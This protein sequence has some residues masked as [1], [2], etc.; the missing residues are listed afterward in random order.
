MAEDN[1]DNRDLIQAYLKETS[2]QVEFAENGQIALNKFIENSYDLILMD[3]EMPVKDGLKTTREI[4]KWEAENGVERTTIVAL[5]AH[6]L[7]EFQ[8]KSHAAGCDAH[9]TKPIKKKTLLDFLNC[10]AET[11]K[12]S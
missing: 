3:M 12:V 7:K 10:F 5:T 4:R 9:L 1:Q 2:H 8:E 6:A 11:G